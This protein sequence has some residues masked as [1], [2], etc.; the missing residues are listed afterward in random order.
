MKRKIYRYDQTILASV[1]P[2]KKKNL[3]LGNVAHSAILGRAVTFDEGIVIGVI[4]DNGIIDGSSS[5]RILASD[6]LTL[7]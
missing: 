6:P 1:P 3:Q 7:P 2:L 5:A 4:E